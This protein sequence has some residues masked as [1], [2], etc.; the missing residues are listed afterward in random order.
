MEGQRIAHPRSLREILHR[1]TV[2]I[3]S[4]SLVD[5]EYRVVSAVAS[6]PAELHE[7]TVMRYELT[8]VG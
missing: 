8:H 2:R 1:L 6:I 3:L 5:R 4:A 7:V